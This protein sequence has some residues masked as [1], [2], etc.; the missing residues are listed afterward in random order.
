MST[1]QAWLKILQPGKTRRRDHIP[2][3]SSEIRMVKGSGVQLRSE[4]LIVAVAVGTEWARWGGAF[5]LGKA[6]MFILY[7]KDSRE[8]GGA[9]NEPRLCPFQLNP[10]A[11]TLM[12]YS[13]LL[14][15]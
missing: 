2:A 1:L 14:G 9:R 10:T 8:T 15:T 12:L 13:V 4:S 6:L 7:S 3:D 11:Q 5:L